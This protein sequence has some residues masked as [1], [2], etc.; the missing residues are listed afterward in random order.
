MKQAV[1]M[2][3]MAVLV[4]AC[5]PKQQPQQA[6]QR[7]SQEQPQSQPQEQTVPIRCELS[8]PAT[9]AAQD[10]AAL[11]FTLINTGQAPLQ[12]LNWQ[13]PF[14][15]IRAPMFNVT[16]DGAEVLYHGV[17]VKRA[18]ATADVEALEVCLRIFPRAALPKSVSG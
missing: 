10:I 15:G 1:S 8:I 6:A 11:K 17:M 18:S 14:E 7:P 2:M 13:T 4:A 16:R 5:S 12:V 9:L 3:M